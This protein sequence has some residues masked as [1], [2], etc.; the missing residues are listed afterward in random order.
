MS[1]HI[2]EAQILASLIKRSGKS[3]SVSATVQRSHRFPV[4]IFTRIENMA[5][6]AEVPVSMIINQLLEAGIEAVSKHISDT[7]LSEIN[8]V[9]QEQ[10]NRLFNQSD[11]TKKSKK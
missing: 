7:E 4:D 1:E 8:K 6:M 10:Y 11:T 2:S 9:S 5:R 3:E